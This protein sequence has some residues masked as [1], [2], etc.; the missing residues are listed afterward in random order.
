KK[1]NGER[2]HNDTEEKR[3][4]QRETDTRGGVDFPAKREQ[5]DWDSARA[6]LSATN[7]GR[8]I[9]KHEY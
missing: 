5:R 9:L 1:H 2:E 8:W 6:L 7:F 4:S 3:R